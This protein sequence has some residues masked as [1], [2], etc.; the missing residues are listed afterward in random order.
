MYFLFQLV[1]RLFFDISEEVDGD[2]DVSHFKNQVSDL[3]V[4][5][6]CLSSGLVFRKQIL[7]IGPSPV[8]K[9]FYF[10][11]KLWPLVCLYNEKQLF[12]PFNKRMCSF[13]RYTDFSAVGVS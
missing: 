8:A 4:C 11:K 6:N 7:Q 10:G 2:E 1:K 3:K 5:A 13:I 9:F 12:C